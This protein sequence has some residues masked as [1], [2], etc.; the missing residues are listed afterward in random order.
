MLFNSLEFALFLPIV[1]FIYWFV[2]GNY[3]IMEY[4]SRRIK[5]LLPIAQLFGL[6]HNNLKLQ[7]AFIVAVSYLFYGWWDWRFLLLIFF[8]SICSWTSGL[9]IEKWHSS[10]KAKWVSA[11]NIILNLGILGFFKYY[12][13]FIE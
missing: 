12:N 9:L 7:N 2:F 8:T 1:F 3:S 11:I 6:W 13:F 5:V 10:S 4:A